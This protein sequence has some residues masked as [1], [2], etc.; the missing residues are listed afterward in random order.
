MKAFCL[1]LVLLSAAGLLA[2]GQT[3]SESSRQESIKK[4]SFRL[5][6]IPTFFPALSA[7]TATRPLTPRQKFRLFL[8]NT[9][10]PIPMFEAAA[11]A[12]ISQGLNETPGFGQGGE[13]YAKR[14]GAAYADTAST[15][16]FG[17]FLYPALFRQD[18]RYFKKLYGSFWSRFEYSIS[19]TFVTRTDTG[20]S[21]P[22]IS[23]WMASGT[24]ALLSNAYYPADSNSAGDA[25]VR[26]GI[27]FASQAGFNVA[28]EF[29]PD[30]K[31]KL[32]P[33]KK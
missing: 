11:R 7:V 10:N 32:F 19:R 29:W 2:Q 14:F 9:A 1:A 6:R 8:Y 13:G 26:F 18:P 33:P 31:R 15:Q 30:L 12:G 24:S 23:F 20:K 4:K 28:K 22:N 5:D 25:A 16:F 17:V 21:A 3:S 27:D